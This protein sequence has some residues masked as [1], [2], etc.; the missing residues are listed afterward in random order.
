MPALLAPRSHACGVG[1]DSSTTLRSPWRMRRDARSISAMCPWPLAL[2]SRRRER[3]P[4]ALTAQTRA[5]LSRSRPPTPSNRHQHRSG[6]RRRCIWP[7]A[8]RVCAGLV[9]TPRSGP[10]TTT[11]SHCATRSCAGQLILRTRHSA[12]Q[13]QGQVLL[14]GQRP[15]AARRIGRI[16]GA[17]GLAGS[18]RVRGPCSQQRPSLSLSSPYCLL[19]PPRP[20]TSE[21]RTGGGVQGAATPLPQPACGSPWACGRAL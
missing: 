2:P 1:A 6:G 15:V 3:W 9:P 11:C 10:R 20:S 18:R 14:Q 8:W 16:A 19:P 5:R 21:D 4:R 12:M 7:A 17:C 13:L